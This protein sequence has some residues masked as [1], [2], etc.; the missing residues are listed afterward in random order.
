MIEF[1]Q[2]WFGAKFPIHRVEFQYIPFSSSLKE[3]EDKRLHPEKFKQDKIRIVKLERAALSWRLTAKE[4]A[5]LKRTIY[6]LRNQ[7]SIKQLE[8]LL[9][10][11]QQPPKSWK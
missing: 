3:I 11:K 9:I 4:K 10:P 7:F 8:K 5:S 6:E 1:S 2:A